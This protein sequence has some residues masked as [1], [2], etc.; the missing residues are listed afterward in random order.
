MQQP[1]PTPPSATLVAEATRRSGVVWV[2]RAGEPPALVWHLWH[3]GSAWLLGGGREQAGEQVLPVGPGDDAVVVVRSKA[4]QA[5]VV[6]TWQAEVTA[7]E[8]GTPTWDEV[9]PL[10][11]AERLNAPAGSD[12][13]WAQEC[14]VLRLTP[15]S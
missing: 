4:A 7:V 8:P 1:A 2:G 10:L 15:R 9:L 14:T 5:G 13:R 3:D 11:A 12:G 6:V